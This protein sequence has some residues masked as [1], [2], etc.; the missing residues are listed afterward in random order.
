MKKVCLYTCLLKNN[1]YILNKLY[2]SLIITN[3]TG[4]GSIK[5]TVENC[6]NSL[7]HPLIK[8]ANLFAKT[9][10]K[11]FENKIIEVCINSENKIDEKSINIEK[12]TSLF[13]YAF[14]C[15]RFNVYKY[16]KT[17]IY[18]DIYKNGIAVD[19]NL[20]S[21]PQLI[22]S[23]EKINSLINKNSSEI[24]KNV[25]AFKI[26]QKWKNYKSN[27]IFYEKIVPKQFYFKVKI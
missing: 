6:S 13:Y 18:G 1:N 7:T 11:F 17:I 27:K 25:C 9:D 26:Q 14:C 15:F 5:F 3:A 21:I 8:A 12:L 19:K 10:V 2:F 23:K 4:K 22:N 24:L 16:P 20:M